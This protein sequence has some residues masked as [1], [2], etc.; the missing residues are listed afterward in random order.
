MEEEGPS[1]R[2]A[3]LAAGLGG[4]SS[5]SGLSGLVRRAPLRACEAWLAG[6]TPC[7]TASP[8]LL[9]AKTRFSNLLKA[10]VHVLL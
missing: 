2:W 9:S 3:V 10:Y 7:R 4:L 1:S 6:V 8:A 5:G